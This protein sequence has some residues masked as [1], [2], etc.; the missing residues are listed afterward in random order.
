MFFNAATA[1]QTTLNSNLP[2][3]AVM[4]GSSIKPESVSFTA[5]ANNDQLYVTSVSSGRIEI[6]GM[7]SGPGFRPVQIINQLTGTPGGPGQYATFAYPIAGGGVVPSENMT[8]T[9]GVLTVGAVN[10]GTVALGQ[11]VANADVP[12]LT[13]IEYN[14]SARRRPPSMNCSN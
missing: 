4:T 6:G 11:E 2:V 8:E 13:G 9:Y 7:I 14:R 3:A 10:S 12:P 1:I 5:N